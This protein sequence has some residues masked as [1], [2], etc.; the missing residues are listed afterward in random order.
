MP[1]IQLGSQQ[2]L[3]VFGV[4]YI[5]EQHADET[6][7]NLSTADGEATGIGLLWLAFYVV[8]AFAAVSHKI[9]HMI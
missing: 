1:S 3:T 7:C 6:H 8:I 5:A 9:G 2:V 4:G